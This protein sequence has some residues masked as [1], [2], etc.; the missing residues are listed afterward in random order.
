LDLQRNQLSGNLS[1]I[2]ELQYLPINQ[3]HKLANNQ[4]SCPLPLWAPF[5]TPCY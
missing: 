3:G 1:A 5:A 2:P 4:F